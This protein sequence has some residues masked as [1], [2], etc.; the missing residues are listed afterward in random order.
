MNSARYTANGSEMGKESVN[1]HLH[2]P[3]NSVPLSN[4]N[5][6][7]RFTERAK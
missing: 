2:N 6:K 4:R 3:L 5:G 7:G 1:R